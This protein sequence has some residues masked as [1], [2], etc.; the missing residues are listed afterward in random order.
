[1]ASKNKAIVVLLTILVLGIL[2]IGGFA[3]YKLS[4]PQ[5]GFG[6]CKASSD[7]PA[8]YQCTNG[9]CEKII[10]NTLKGKAA[11][12]SVYAYDQAA[13]S[14]QSTK[15]IV[16]LY[17]ITNPVIGAN[18]VTGDSFAADGAVLSSSARTDVTE[19]LTVGTS[20]AA[21]AV[22][23]TYYGQWSPATTISSQAMTL[24]LNGYAVA[25]HGGNIVLRDK[26][27]V[28]ITPSATGTVNLTLGATETEG[29]K[30][31]RIENNNSNKAWNVLGWYID[32]ATGSNISKF[33]VGS[34]GTESNKASLSGVGYTKGGNNL[35]RT[36]NDDEIF[37]FNE[38]LL[39]LEY[40]KVEVADMQ[41]TADGDG[42]AVGDTF[43]IYVF[44]G[45]WYRSAKTNSMKFGAETDADSPSDVGASD[46]SK[47]YACNA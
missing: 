1:M 11:T 34:G 5:T 44:D 12:V 35:I 3:V 28:T 10:E 6:A 25:A 38:P 37:Y 22:N 18:E 45:S 7:C 19:G 27:D 15:I 36:D 40:D 16:P 46:F 14:P 31:F 32:K 30:Y 20:F 13:N 43:T 33:T 21:I 9:A 42:C 41:V 24:D 8:G 29:F 47:A 23:D 39:L 26:D 2:G 17:L 4:T